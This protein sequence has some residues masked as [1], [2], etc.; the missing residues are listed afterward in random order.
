MLALHEFNDLLQR[1]GESRALF[2]LG[3]HRTTLYRW[4]SGKVSIPKPVMY[5]MRDLAY[6][7]GVDP[8]WDGWKFR[9][10]KLLGPG[11]EAFTPGDLLAQRHERFA[12]DA[13][14]REN[15]DLKRKVESLSRDAAVRSGAAND[16]AIDFIPAVSPYP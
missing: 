9:D 5:V 4:Q 10:G 16:S 15:A 12:L 7:A 1:V 2:E 6:G 8:D 11:R 14:R 3:V 13:Y